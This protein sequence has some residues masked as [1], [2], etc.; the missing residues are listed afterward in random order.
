[1]FKLSKTSISLDSAV[2]S[3]VEE[4]WE[5][6]TFLEEPQSRAVLSGKSFSVN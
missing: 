5:P 4:F 3:L 2:S 1:M 6:P